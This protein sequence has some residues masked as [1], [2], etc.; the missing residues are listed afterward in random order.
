MIVLKDVEDLKTFKGEN[1][2]VTSLY[3]NIDGNCFP[4]DELPLYLKEL[5]KKKKETLSSST[6]Y[7]K[8]IKVSAERDLA[9][10]TRFIESNLDRKKRKG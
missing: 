10:I 8:E 7:S 5:I 4:P 1:F 9:K 6:T 3:L 2:L